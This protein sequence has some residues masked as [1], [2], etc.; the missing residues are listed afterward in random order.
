[1]NDIVS[2]GLLVAAIVFL[3]NGVRSWRDDGI[4]L[5]PVGVSCAVVGASGL[6]GQK[7]LPVTLAVFVAMVIAHAVRYYS[8][9]REDRAAVRLEFSLALVAS[10]ATVAM[11]GLG[12]AGVRG[13]PLNIS[14]GAVAVFS[15]AFLVVSL[16]RLVRAG[17][18]RTA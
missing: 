8:W 13:M 18:D 16:T 4:R 17:A 12:L 9:T 7:L 1:M 3:V 10:A 15:S 2:Y 5:I 14:I 11:A 6:I